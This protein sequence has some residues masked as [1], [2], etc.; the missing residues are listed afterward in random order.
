M[1]TVESSGELHS[2]DSLHVPVGTRFSSGRARPGKFAAVLNNEQCWACDTEAYRP[3]TH[4]IMFNHSHLFYSFDTWDCVRC[5]LC[6]VAILAI[7]SFLPLKEDNNMLASWYTYDVGVVAKDINGYWEKAGRMEDGIPGAGHN[8]KYKNI[9][10]MDLWQF[11]YQ[12]C[13]YVVRF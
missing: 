8:I 2:N 4:H 10:T 6:L 12:T 7:S 13:I 3:K 1:V 5:M 9:I 11:C